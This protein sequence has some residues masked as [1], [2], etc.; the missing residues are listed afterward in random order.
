MSYEKEIKTQS[1]LEIRFFH[2]CQTAG[3]LVEPQYL[4]GQIHADFA[5]V[6]KK[7]AIECDS[8]EFH[9]DWKAIE[10]DKFRDS[11][12]NYMG[13]TVI[14]LSGSEIYKNGE[15]I[16][17]AIRRAIKDGNI[18]L[19]VGYIEEEELVSKLDEN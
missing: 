1:P 19:Y 17:H 6:D 11:I 13:W 5:I 4:I 7:I 12:Y 18:D 3:L 16:A 14:R 8:K 15:K 2:D 10:N 9:S